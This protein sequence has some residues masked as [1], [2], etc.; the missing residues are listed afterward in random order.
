MCIPH[1]SVPSAQYHLPCL[2]L[3][4][5]LPPS[6]SLTLFSSRPLV[7]GSLPLFLSS[8]LPLFH[9]LPLSLYTPPL[10]V[11]SLPLVLSS[12]RPLSCEARGREGQGEKGKERCMR[13]KEEGKSVTDRKEIVCRSYTVVREDRKN[14]LRADHNKVVREDGEER[15]GK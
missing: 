15:E 3:P 10:G 12:S 2:L 4:P 1:G 6:L 8:T 14:E 13:S 11:L 7:F 5:S 9:S